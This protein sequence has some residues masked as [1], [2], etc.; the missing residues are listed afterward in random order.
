MYLKYKKIQKKIQKKNTKKE[1]SLITLLETCT[2]A[3]T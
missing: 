3:P 1:V 2:Q